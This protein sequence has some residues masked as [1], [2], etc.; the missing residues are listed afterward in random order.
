MRK[1]KKRLPPDWI[2]HLVANG[3]QCKDCGE[4]ENCFPNGICNAHTHGME[5]YGHVDFQMV[6]HVSQQEIC[7]VLN[8]L[9]NRVRAG[10]KFSAG[11]LVYGIFEDCPIR[12]DA[13]QEC[14]RTVLRVII[15][16]GQNRFP[17]DEHCK[18]PYSLQIFTLEALEAMKK[19]AEG[20]MS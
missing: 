6:L 7:Y 16:D 13:F 14:D 5:K 10:E 2:I 17:E 1:P 19:F 12:L 20:Q 3:I 18:Y 9:G 4:V 8:T 15:P 11:D